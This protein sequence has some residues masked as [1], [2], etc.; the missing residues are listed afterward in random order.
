MRLR[1]EPAD[2]GTVGRSTWTVDFAA[3]EELRTEISAKFRPAGIAAELAGG[4]LRRARRS[5]PT[6]TACSG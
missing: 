3:G 6:R 4:R 2:A 1:A 5:G